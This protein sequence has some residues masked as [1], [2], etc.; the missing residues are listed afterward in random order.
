MMLSE[1][2]K[3]IFA[4]VGRLIVG[5]E[6]DPEAAVKKLE[7]TFFVDVDFKLDELLCTVF[8]ALRI[9]IL[10]RGNKSPSKKD[11]MNLLGKE[12]WMTIFNFV[13]IHETIDTAIKASIH[14]SEDRTLN[15]HQTID[16][17]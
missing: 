16:H 17:E 9:I 13:W 15:N 14:D 2:R 10:H 11:V 7:R 5:L 8:L 12:H 4:D 6:E 1:R 3:R